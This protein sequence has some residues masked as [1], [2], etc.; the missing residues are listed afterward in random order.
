M[1][2]QIYT[3]SVWLMQLRICDKNCYE[4][5]KID[6]K[7]LY[8]FLSGRVIKKNVQYSTIFK[9]ERFEYLSWLRKILRDKNEE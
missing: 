5:K 8:N 2:I 9:M 1:I 3:K 6:A 4:R 7:I